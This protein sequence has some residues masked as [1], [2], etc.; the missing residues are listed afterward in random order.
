MV[1][2]LL[3]RS[4]VPYKPMRSQGRE[5][6]GFGRQDADPRARQHK[7][8]AAGSPPTLRS[9]GRKRCS[10]RRRS[11]AYDHRMHVRRG[12]SRQLGSFHQAAVPSC[13]PGRGGDGDKDGFISKLA[14]TAIPLDK[15]SASR[16]PSS[17]SKRHSSKGP[18]ESA[19]SD[20]RT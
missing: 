16:K 15:G 10:S 12:P 13:I 14:G 9:I 19:L 20:D 4:A 7:G 1:K 17:R 3:D 2:V 18:Q 8:W 11:S 6:G 5:L